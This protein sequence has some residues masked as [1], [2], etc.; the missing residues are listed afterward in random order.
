MIFDSALIFHSLLPF[1][2]A[3]GVASEVPSVFFIWCAVD[4][5]CT[6][7]QSCNLAVLLSLLLQTFNSLARTQK[8]MQSAR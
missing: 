5:H 7:K 8:E 6:L 3:V 4:K 1:N 2:G